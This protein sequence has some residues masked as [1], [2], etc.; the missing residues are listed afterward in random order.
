MPGDAHKRCTHPQA[1]PEGISPLTFAFSFVGE[2][3]CHDGWQALGIIADMHGVKNGWFCWPYNF[4]PI[5]LKACNGFEPSLA[6]D[7][8]AGDGND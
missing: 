2:P 7:P 1:I 8:M 3:Q 5:W 6:Y 4:D